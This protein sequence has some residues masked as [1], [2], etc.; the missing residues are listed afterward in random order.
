MK[1][2]SSFSY[3]FEPLEP[4]GIL[5]ALAPVEKS[6]PS[7]M[8]SSQGDDDEP[9][10]STGTSHHMRILYRENERLRKDLEDCRDQLF[11]IM[12][13][14]NDIPEGDIKNAFNM[15]YS[16]IDSWIDEVSCEETLE[17][18]FKKEFKRKAQNKSSFAALGL[19]P[20]CYSD[21]NWLVGQLG[22]LRYCL[23]IVVSL[24]IS[25]FLMDEIFR[26]EQTDHWGN[27]YP[28]GL[29][30]EQIE[31]LVETQVKMKDKLQRGML[32]TIL[33]RPYRNF[34]EDKTLNI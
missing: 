26:N 23:H 21:I 20:Q 9:G 24:A 8:A 1:T 18:S 31:F 27:L 11:Q 12:Q 13:K 25:K 32:S 15:I 17:E 34:D 16:G 14:G 7:A 28:H 19:H 6:R 22:K 4:F 5:I 33:T 2:A 30:D 10:S 3:S 29:S